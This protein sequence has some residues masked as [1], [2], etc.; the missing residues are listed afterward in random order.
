M[1][2]REGRRRG[3]SAVESDGPDIVSV[4][5]IEPEVQQV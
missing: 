2:W 5:P 3:I 1:A 4:G